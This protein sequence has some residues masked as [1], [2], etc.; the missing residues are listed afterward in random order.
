MHLGVDG[1]EKCV[2]KSGR[3]GNCWTNIRIV[4]SVA[5]LVHRVTGK[6]SKWYVLLDLCMNSS[7][8][9]CMVNSSNTMAAY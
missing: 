4:R 7:M 2:N 1:S 6:L 5:H 3:F 8:P 9:G